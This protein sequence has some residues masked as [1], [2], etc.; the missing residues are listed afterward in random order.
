[1]RVAVSSSRAPGGPASANVSSSS[2]TSALRSGAKSLTCRVPMRSDARQLML[3]SRSPG[4]CGRSSA[5]S[6]P[7]P[8][9][10]AG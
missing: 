10:G 5:I 3:R 4:T 6:S 9:V 8:M 1:M 7:S 2:T